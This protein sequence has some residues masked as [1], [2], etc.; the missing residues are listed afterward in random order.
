MVTLVSAQSI[1]F[2][3]SSITAKVSPV[4][5]ARARYERTGARKESA[6]E[7]LRRK[8]KMEEFFTSTTT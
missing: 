1:Y 2:G 5:S 7:R 4:G 3:L 6:D 8:S